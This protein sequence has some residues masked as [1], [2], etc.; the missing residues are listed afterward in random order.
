[1]LRRSSAIFVLGF[2]ALVV[3]C[4]P[5]SSQQAQATPVGVVIMNARTTNTGYTTYP[6][7]NFYKVGQATFTFATVNSDSCVVAP[8]NS[9]TTLTNTAK[10]IGAGAYMIV[11][12]SGDTDSL[13]K[14]TTSDQTYAPA[15]LAGLTFNPGDSLSF[16]IAGD[17]AGFPNLRGAGRT[18]E[19]FSITTPT[20]PPLGQSMVINW[21]PA[22]DDNAAMYI[23]LIYNSNAFPGSGANTQIFCDFHDDGQGT[24][25]ANL[26]PALN[27]SNIPFTVFAQRVRSALLVSSPNVANAYINVI[28]T[29]EVPTP[30][31]P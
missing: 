30:V 12:L 31:S 22:T 23:S 10:R 25:Q 3:A 18:A 20:I 14:A 29:F 4:D 6:K 21:T 24:V 15:A 27:S 19:P 1:M 17:A 11:A 26:I 28:S 5:Y 8:Y 13:Y 2:V 7:I 16:I 9:N